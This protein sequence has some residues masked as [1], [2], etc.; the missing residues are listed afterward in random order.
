MLTETL[1]AEKEEKDDGYEVKCGT[2]KYL[3]GTFNQK[4]K[5]KL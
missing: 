3:E 5:F 2:G 4:M 1:K